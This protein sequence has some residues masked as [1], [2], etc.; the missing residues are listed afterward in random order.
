MAIQKNS[1]KESNHHKHRNDYYDPIIDD[2]IV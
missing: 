1:E 2:H